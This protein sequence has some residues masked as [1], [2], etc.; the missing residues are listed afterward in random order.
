MRDTLPTWVPAL[1]LGG[2]LDNLF[3]RVAFGYVHDFLATARIVLNLADVAILVGLAAP[4]R[5][6]RARI[7]DGVEARVRRHATVP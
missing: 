2:S 4:A 6:Y 1:L 3:V 5:A 7:T